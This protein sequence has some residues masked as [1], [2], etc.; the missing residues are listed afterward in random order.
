MWSTTS[1]DYLK[2]LLSIHNPIMLGIIEPKQLNSKLGELA[3]KLGFSG[4]CHGNDANNHIWLFWNNMVSVQVLEV[5]PQT[6]Y[7]KIG[8]P[9]MAD[10][11]LSAVYAKCTTPERLELWE[12]L[13]KQSQITL[14]WI[15]GGDFNPILTLTK[16]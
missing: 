7:V 1:S 5:T 9:G 12:D 2:H 15:V 16:K 3:Y 10:F 8:T 14:P 11:L 6:L 13:I 4:Y